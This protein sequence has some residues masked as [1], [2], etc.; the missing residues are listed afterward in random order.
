MLV[1]GAGILGAASA[2]HIKKNNPN[3]TVL[4]VD[5]YPS[6]AQGNTGRSNAMF[7]NTF[8]SPDNQIL[9]DCSINFYIDL[10]SKAN[11]GLQRIGYLWLVSEEGFSKSKRSIESM[12][13]N[14]IEIKTFQ[15]EE[16]RKLVPF[17]NTECKET[18]TGRLMNLP[19]VA[20]GIFG[21]KC[22]RLDP[23]KLTNFYIDE[24]LKLGGKVAFNTEVVKLN[25]AP[26][27]QIGVEGEPFVW[28]DTEI[29]SVSVKGHING[30]IYAKTTVLACGA[31]M[32]RLLEPIG[33]DGHVK[34]KKRQLFSISAKDEKLG[35][36]LRTNGFN[37]LGLL[38]MVILP[39]AAVHFKPVIEENAFWVGC[40]DEI[41]RKYINIPESN[42]D[43]YRA[44]P[45]YYERNVLPILSSYFPAFQS[46]RPKA[47]WAGL[48]SY[49]TADYLPFVFKEMNLIAVGGDSGSGIMKADS[50]ARIVNAVYREERYAMLYGNKEYDS[51]RIGF[52]HRK[53]EREEWVI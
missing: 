43:S 51:E 6:A 40:E 12:L 35:R 18:E 30:E 50:I 47:M 13:Q 8:T 53:V 28:Q 19:D 45:E 14:G 9:S 2:F 27:N 23:V 39:K 42:L 4:V 17:L 22:G 3:K 10:Q 24:F 48:Y 34:A 31:W 11:I 21:P 44:E 5:S 32:N 26:V 49:N 38:P 20:E 52:N 37:D 16:L 15:K 29:K 25:S 41:N 7:R 46:A 36:L 1:I 33:I